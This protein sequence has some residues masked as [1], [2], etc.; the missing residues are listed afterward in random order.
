MKKAIANPS[1][2]T[3]YDQIYPYNINTSSLNGAEYGMERVGYIPPPKPSLNGGLY[4]GEEFE[5]TG[6]HR[7]YPVKPDSVNYHVNNLKSAN[8]PPGVLHQFPDSIRPG[9]NLP[10]TVALGLS[11]YSDQHSI[12]CT[13]PQ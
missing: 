11:R 8:P 2:T 1:G 7:N 3:N 13:K 12:M 10:D 4:T 5:I 6:G 9:N